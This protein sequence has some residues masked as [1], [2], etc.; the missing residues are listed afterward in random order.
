MSG[1]A[2]GR[3]AGIRSLRT[4]CG[5]LMKLNFT[6]NFYGVLKDGMFVYLWEAGVVLQK[7]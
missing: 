5:I 4:I 1:K 7:I 3:Q 2:R 6:L